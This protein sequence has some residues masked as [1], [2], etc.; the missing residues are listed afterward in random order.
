MLIYINV[1][2]KMKRIA[3]IFPKNSEA[4]FN[5]NSV[6][7]FGGATVQLY[8]ITKKLASYE[9]LQIYSL[10][11]KFQ[12][13]SD[14]NN[15]DFNLINTFDKNDL[16]PVKVFKLAHLL[17]RIR[18]H[19]ILQRGLTI[20]SC[21][22]SLYCRM[23]GIKFVF[24]YAHDREVQGRYQ[25]NNNKC[26]LYRILTI[27]SPALIVQSMSQYNQ[28]SIKIRKK[29]YVIKNGYEMPEYD[30]VI[31][32][33]KNTILWVGRLEPMKRPDIFI[34]LA[35]YFKKEQ[36]IMIGAVRDDLKEYAEQ[37]I[38][39]IS[40][41]ENIK[42]INFVH[43]H[44]IDK[45]FQSAKV[46][47]NTSEA[48]G[49]PNTFIQAGLRQTPV[50]SLNVN[51]DNFITE[52]NAGSFCKNDFNVLK[53]SLRTILSD[54]KNF[55]IKSQNIYNYTTLNHNIDITVD[56]L[57]NILTSLNQGAPETKP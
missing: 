39:E 7:P 54:E 3:V 9:D 36:F 14:N 55:K 48:E 49:F 56:R 21:L 50:V 32:N 22:L 11:N 35:E 25:R 28:L 16:F 5:K 2:K 8:N 18:P 37:I 23:T 1:N 45:F 34:K 13:I 20:E 51:P 17:A 24:M 15:Q 31:Y 42:Y 19:I 41:N 47:V 6:E 12:N 46:L 40:R 10:I 43:H 26:Y 30:T 53:E 57:K 44:L 29:S 38:A 27:C 4:L 52:N 33:K